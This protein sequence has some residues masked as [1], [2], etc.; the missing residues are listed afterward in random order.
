MVLG[1]LKEV[2][3]KPAR[4]GFITSRKVGGAVARN[5]VRRRLR[6]VVRLIRPQIMGGTWLVIVAKP[7]AAKATQA[8][9]RD[10]WAALARRAGILK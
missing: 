3:E 1:V 8:A 7:R 5:L 10:E 2:D 6:E 9:L 4:I